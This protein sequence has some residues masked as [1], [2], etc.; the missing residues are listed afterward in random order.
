MSLNQVET[1]VKMLNQITANNTAYETNEAAER[2]ANHITRFWA[3]SMKEDLQEYVE[4][5]GDDLS[6]VSEMAANI[7]INNMK[8]KTP[9]TA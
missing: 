1:L 3:R 9:A 4:A 8:E 7:V 6:P 5:G 2:V